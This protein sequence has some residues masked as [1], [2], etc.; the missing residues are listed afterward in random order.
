MDR[1][2]SWLG[3]NGEHTEEHASVRRELTAQRTRLRRLDAYVE[4]RSIRH[5]R[6]RGMTASHPTRR[7]DD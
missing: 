2:R 1:F 4:A 6:R 7:A 5:D 3:V